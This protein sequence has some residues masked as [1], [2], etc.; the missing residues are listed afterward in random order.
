M[1]SKIIGASTPYRQSSAVI[2]QAAFGASQNSEAESGTM[3]GRKSTALSAQAL[4]PNRRRVGTRPQFGKA[5]GESGPLTARSSV[6]VKNG[7][8]GRFASW[9]CDVSAVE[10]LG[11][12][13]H[14]AKFSS[15]PT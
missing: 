15:S 4:P 3:T 13:G 6:P 2:G 10:R 9:K 8:L 1:L 14:L 5:L 11:P 12:S 7:E